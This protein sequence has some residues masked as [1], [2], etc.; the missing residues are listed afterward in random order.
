MSD[1][2]EEGG[3]KA[4]FYYDIKFVISLLFIVFT[5]V[6]FLLLGLGLL[7]LLTFSDFGVVT[8]VF[9]SL[10][11]YLDLQETI[12]ARIPR[13]GWI[14]SKKDFKL[15]SAFLLVSLLLTPIGYCLLSSGIAAK[16]PIAFLFSSALLIVP[17]LL[18]IGFVL[19]CYLAMGETLGYGKKDEEITK[20]LLKHSYFYPKIRGR[21]LAQKQN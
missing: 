20:T 1:S 10:M 13:Y 18:G 7:T 6:S 16:H 9:L 3:S 8:L 14:C 17:I 21:K 2:C 11:T 12:E 5:V 15:A 4:G 19:S